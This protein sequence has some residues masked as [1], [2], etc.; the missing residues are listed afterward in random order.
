MYDE[1]YIFIGF[2][3]G[4]HIIALYALIRY[5]INFKKKIKTEETISLLKNHI[6]IENKFQYKEINDDYIKNI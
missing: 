4:L 5:N 1:N 3:G 2:I 6:D